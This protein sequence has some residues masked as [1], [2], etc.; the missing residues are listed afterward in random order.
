MFSIELNITDKLI[1]SK[2][3]VC[4]R[5][6]WKNQIGMHYRVRAN[7]IEFMWLSFLSLKNPIWISKKCSEVCDR[8]LNNNNREK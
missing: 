7:S 8:G 5:L 1:A 6:L 3:I 2:P 4:S